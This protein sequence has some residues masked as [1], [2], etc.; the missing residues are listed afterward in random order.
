MINIETSIIICQSAIKVSAVLVCYEYEKSKGHNVIIIVRNVKSIYDFVQS[1]SLDADVIWFDNYPCDFYSLL[2]QKKMKSFVEHQMSMIPLKESIIGNVYFTSICHDV[3][4]CCYLS[5]FPKEKIIKL[6][7]WLD[8]SNNI[9]AYTLPKVAYSL[10]WKAKCFFYSLFLH[11]RL[12]LQTVVSP[13]LAIDIGY[14]R[15]PLFNGS[16]TSVCDSYLYMPKG[17]KGK[18][19]LV[20]ASE[21][22]D[23][24]KD[25]SDYVYSFVSCIRRLKKEGYSVYLKGHPRIGTLPE[26][27]EEADDEIPS[28]VP[29]EFLDYTFFSSAFGLTS[30]AICSSSAYIPSYSLLPLTKLVNDENYTGWCDYLNKTSGGK[31]KYLNSLDDIS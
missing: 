11:Y 15:F 17:K 30:S 31:V 9:D 12:R 6:Q 28:Y 27:I 16:D 18:N 14:Y 26:A 3:P 2:R 1:L 20:F 10:R 13:A 22:V 21:Y 19:A 8:I 24:F 29:A 7:G 25:R 4:M 5:R 23:V